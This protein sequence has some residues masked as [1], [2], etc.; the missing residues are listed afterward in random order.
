MYVDEIRAYT[1]QNEQEAADQ[2]L[3]LEYIRL[4]GTTFSPGQRDRPSVQLRLCGQCRRH[5]G[6]HGPPQYLQGVGLDGRPCGWGGRPALRGPAGG[7]GGDGGGAYPSPQPRH[8]L[9][10]HSARVGPREAREVGALPSASQCIL[11]AGG[12]RGADILRSGGRTAG[13][14]GFRR[15]ACWS[16]PTS[17]RRRVRQAVIGRGK[18]AAGT[19]SGLRGRAL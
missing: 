8:R 2:W 7:P 14:A 18:L 6:A 13:W 17:G 9:P 10:G 3:I 12:R 11:P 19:H 15:S 4:F 1:P 16:T 5:P